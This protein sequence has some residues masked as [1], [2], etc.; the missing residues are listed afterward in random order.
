MI[1]PLE[2]QSEIL[3]VWTQKKIIYKIAC[4]PIAFSDV[5][6]NIFSTAPYIIHENGK[7]AEKCSP[8]VFFSISLTLIML[9]IPSQR[10]VIH[11]FSELSRIMVLLFVSKRATTSARTGVTFSSIIFWQLALEFGRST[12][13]GLLSIHFF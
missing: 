7:F 3:W 5:T 10:F 12:I 2:K 8:L 1:K 9:K 4:V 6:W 13:L 11:V